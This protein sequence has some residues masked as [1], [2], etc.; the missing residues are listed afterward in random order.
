[1][2]SKL[3]REHQLFDGWLIGP[4]YSKN[5]TLYFLAPSQKHLMQPILV[6][7]E[8]PLRSNF[9]KKK[10]WSYLFFFLQ[11]QALQGQ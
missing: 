7:Y 3:L 10:Q 2:G 4:A 8:A 5:E 1:M 11:M 6:S 9:Q